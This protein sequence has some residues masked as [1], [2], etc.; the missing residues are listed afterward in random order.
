MD[1]AMNPT[2]PKEYGRRYFAGIVGRENGVC[3]LAE[4][5][6]GAVGYV[7]GY[8]REGD[9]SRPVVVA[10]LES[11]YVRDAARDR[12][13]GTKLALR[14]LG[15]AGSRGAERA[16]GNA[17]A[18]NGR[19]ICFYERMGFRPRSLSMEMVLHGG[20]KVLRLKGPDLPLPG[21]GAD[22]QARWSVLPAALAR[23]AL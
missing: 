9:P 13:V 22:A 18:S 1:P 21:D 12:G 10:R 2:W 5:S 4:V 20:A 16:S 7:A 8:V 14:F 3:L 23:H 6:G 11:M 19:A 17:Y 15:W